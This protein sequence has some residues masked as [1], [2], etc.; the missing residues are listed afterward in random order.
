MAAVTHGFVIDGAPTERYTSNGGMEASVTFF[1]PASNRMQF[2]SEIFGRWDYDDWIGSAP[3]KKPTAVC[4]RKP[5]Q[6][7][8]SLSEVSSDGSVC[9]DPDRASFDE[10]H[11]LW[12]DTWEIA[13]AD[14]NSQAAFLA[15]VNPPNQPPTHPMQVPVDYSCMCY[16]VVHYRTKHHACWP[17]NYRRKN[18]QWGDPTGNNGGVPRIPRGTYLDVKSRAS[19]EV[20]TVEGKFIKFGDPGGSGPAGIPGAK[21]S[22]VPSSIPKNVEGGVTV[23]MLISTTQIDVTWSSVPLPPWN[24]IDDLTGKVNRYSFLGYPP[25]AVCFM[26][27]DF[28]YQG[29]LGCMPLYTLH[30]NFIVKTSPVMKEGSPSLGDYT[31]ARVIEAR[32]DIGIWNRRMAP[33]TIYYGASPSQAIVTNFVPIFSSIGDMKPFELGDFHELFLMQDWNNAYNYVHN[34]PSS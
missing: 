9:F 10:A 30:Y 7:Y 20:Q 6:P 1:G 15:C 33:S 23:G 8:V 12:P 14:P 27:A 24:L 21:W 18:I 25:E 2:I 31:N 11:C 34:C 13:P 32:G 5:P 26:G 28:S 29:G 4:L 22:G 19:T 16:V 17:L 3:D